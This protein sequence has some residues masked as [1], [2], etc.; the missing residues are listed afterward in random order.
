VLVSPIGIIYKN[1]I[2]LK[3]FIICY[4][5]DFKKY[6]LRY[7]IRTLLRSRKQALDRNTKYIILFDNYS[8]PHGFAHWLCDS[9][10]RIAEVNDELDQYTAVFPDYF[11]REKLYHQTLAFFNFGRI[12][13]LG[14]HD[15]TRIPELYVPSHIASTG[16]FR[17]ENIQKLRQIVLPQVKPVKKTFDHIYISRARSTRRY[18]ENEDEV[19]AYLRTLEFE[20]LYFEDYSFAEQ[21]ALIHQA[22][23][24]VSIHGAALALIMFM[25][26]NSNVLEFRKKDDASNNMYYYLSNAAHVNYNY[27]RCD[28]TEVAAN[29]NSFNLRVDL[30]SLRQTMERM[31]AEK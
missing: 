19:C 13:Y 23:T 30:E 15:L 4:T 31:L 6:K 16:V 29:A 25:K 9:L 5:D 2:S 11:N 3:Q 7:L 14:D 28:Y 18:V 22:K 10:T 1:F 27:L 21:V 17:S 26:D 8:G 24:V 20:V 12:V